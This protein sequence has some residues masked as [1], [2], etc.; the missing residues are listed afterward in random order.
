MPTSVKV[1]L[2]KWQTLAQV[3][4]ISNSEK[5][6]VDHTLNL[7]IHACVLAQL[8]YILAVAHRLGTHIILAGEIVYRPLIKCCCQH[9]LPQQQGSMESQ[10]WSRVRPFETC[11]A[12][13]HTVRATRSP[14]SCEGFCC[15]L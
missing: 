11:H 3:V 9:C 5:H 6:G 15:V 1:S 12:G 13:T 4:D 14:I 8:N 2:H 7:R 10:G